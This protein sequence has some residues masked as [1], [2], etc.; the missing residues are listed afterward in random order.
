ME[1]FPVNFNKKFCCHQ[2]VELNAPESPFY[3]VVQHNRHSNDEGTPGKNEIGNF[4]CSEECW[5][6]A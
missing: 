2:P 4:H 1:R 6:L 5:P 3:F